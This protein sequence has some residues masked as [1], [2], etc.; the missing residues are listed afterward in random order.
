MKSIL[1]FILTL[2]VFPTVNGQDARPPIE[3]HELDSR[4]T[5]IVAYQKIGDAWIGANYLILEGDSSAVLLDT[6]WDDE[7]TREVLEWAD[8]NLETTIELCVITHSHDDRMGGIAAVHKRNIPTAIHPAAQ[9]M[10]GEFEAAKELILERKAI[11]LGNL[12]LE[13]L[14]PGDGHAPGNLVVKI[15][16][17]GYYGG[18][19][20]KSAKSRSLGNVADANIESWAEAL[21]TIESHIE[22]SRWV[23]PGHGGIEDGAYERT[24]ELVDRELDELD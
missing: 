1:L 8:T 6:P 12:N 21:E 13:V 4:T 3:Y 2:F 9:E 20:L 17:Y 7:Q 5:L 22:G 24:V 15:G 23:I 10:R 19:F 16:N 18:C 11:R 14:Y